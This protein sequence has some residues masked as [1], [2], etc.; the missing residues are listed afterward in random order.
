MVK[1][2]CSKTGCTI[3]DSGT[4]L[5][6][7]GDITSCPHTREKN[8]SEKIDRAES[9]EKGTRV[10]SKNGER[11]FLSGLEIGIEDAASMMKAKY[12]F[13]FGILGPSNAGKTC[14][15]LALYLAAAR[16][17]LPDKYLFAGSETL[18]GF[19]ARA[20]KLR[21]WRG[22]ALPEK[23]ADHTH[24][25]D[26]RNPA[27]LH[28]K[29]K[30]GKSSTRS[31]D[32]LFTDLPGEWSKNLIDS[33]EAAQR[34]QFLKRA[35]GIMIVVDGPQMASRAK[36]VELTR[37]KHLLERLVRSVCVPTKIP[38]AIVVSKSDKIKMT[39]PPEVREIEKYAVDLGFPTKVILCAAFSNNHPKV[40]NGTG[41]IDALEF[42]L[43]GERHSSLDQ[44]VS[45]S[46]QGSRS[47]HNFR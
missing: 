21:N 25:T 38:L 7:L 14:Y 27:F 11:S 43:N 1:R 32:L 24:L 23:L 33:V 22:G 5:M 47:F 35:D 41:V 13:M 44:G 2:Y 26:P 20:R 42:L 37:Y 31:L 39:L 17:A 16:G 46:L 4:C 15:L 8:D 28:L 9:N 18:I 10:A 19:E 36:L 12:C 30:E 45:T 6:S 29:L 34:F 3:L 40:A